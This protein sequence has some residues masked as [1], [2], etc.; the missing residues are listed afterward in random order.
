[1][2]KCL[3]PFK[4]REA[5]DSITKGQMIPFG[6][7]KYEQNDPDSVAMII[8]ESDDSLNIIGVNPIIEMIPAFLTITTNN[9]NYYVVYFIVKF[10]ENDD[11][12]YES[13]FCIAYPDTLNN[14]KKFLCQS[15]MIF[16][17]VGDNI[18]SSVNVNITELFIT[19]CRVMLDGLRKKID[20]SDRDIS[21]Y[22][23]TIK[24]F[25]NVLST[26]L[27]MMSF[28]KEQQQKY[29]SNFLEITLI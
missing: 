24:K 21:D 1:M 14:C 2:N 17:I 18:Y 4:I 3:L 22:I 11:F 23:I 9:N 5:A 29:Q 20:H 27:S 15:P 26:P 16:I 25:Q 19:Q 8:R 7:V 6:G 12:I 28:L 13:A 10:S